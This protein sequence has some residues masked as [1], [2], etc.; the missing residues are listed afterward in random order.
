MYAHTSISK[1]QKKMLRLSQRQ[2]TAEHLAEVGAESGEEALLLHQ[3]TSATPQSSN[4]A[5]DKTVVHSIVF[6]HAPPHLQK[7]ACRTP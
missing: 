4:N 3:S 5:I 6:V 7:V 1:N 2:P